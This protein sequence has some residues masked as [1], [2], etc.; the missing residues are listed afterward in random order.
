M[1]VFLN[2]VDVLGQKLFIGEMDVGKDQKPLRSDNQMS[3]TIL[4]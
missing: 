1:Y 3:G 4:Q 2:P